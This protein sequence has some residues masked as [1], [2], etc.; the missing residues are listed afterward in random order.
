[1]RKLFFVTF[2]LVLMASLVGAESNNVYLPFYSTKKEGLV[3][4][5]SQAVYKNEAGRVNRTDK[6]QSL[7]QALFAGPT[8]SEKAAGYQSPIPPKSKLVNIEM[9]NKDVEVYISKEL[10]ENAAS[11]DEIIEYMEI[12]VAD[13]LIHNLTEDEAPTAVRYWIEDTDGIFRPDTKFTIPGK[14]TLPKHAPKYQPFAAVSPSNTNSP[15]APVEGKFPSTR[16]TGLLSGKRIGINAGHGLR[17]IHEQPFP[18]EN[19]RN[20]ANL[21]RAVDAA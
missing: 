10:L 5:S 14:E 4:R 15:F 19:R 9:K 16:P 3:S 18:P 20:I 13:T 2:G 17:K 11:P 21:H 6:I 8:E 7:L 12:A 1:M